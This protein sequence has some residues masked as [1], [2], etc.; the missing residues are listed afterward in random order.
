LKTLDLS[1]PRSASLTLRGLTLGPHD[2]E[3][4][5]D[6]LKHVPLKLLDL[7][8]SHCSDDGL[9]ALFDMI[10]FYEAA[11]HV[12]LAAHKSMTTRGWQAC[13]RMIKRTERLEWLDAAQIGLSEHSSTLLAK[14]L[15]ADSCLRVLQLNSC[16]LS[17]RPLSIIA[18]SLRINKNLRELYL[19]ENKLTQFDALQLGNLLSGNSSL[20]IIDLR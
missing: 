18:S 1:N 15:R 19:A 5:E 7:G 4:L 17:G 16:S 10:E 8:A 6:V 3:S 9:I 20:H 11:S 2:C 12:S 13:C 14:A